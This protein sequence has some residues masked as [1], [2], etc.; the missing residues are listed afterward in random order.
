M[1]KVHI[2]QLLCPSRHCIVAL[3]YEGNDHEKHKADLEANIERLVVEKKVIHPWCGLCG[4]KRE[5]WKY[6]T[7]PTTFS[8]IEEAMPTLAA[9][10]EAQIRA[11]ECLQAAGRTFDA[12][13]LN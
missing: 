2:I 1:S 12:A 10:Q 6:E 3:A 7:A 8:T 9:I 13:K 4:A 11:A 5:K